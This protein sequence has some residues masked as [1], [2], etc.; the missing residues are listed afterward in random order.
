VRAW[1]RLA[2][3][4]TPLAAAVA[5][6]G[7]ALATR[8]HGE[9]SWH[10]RAR[11]A[12]ADARVL[13]RLDAARRRL[14]AHHSAPFGAMQ[15]GRGGRNGGTGGW[16]NAAGHGGGAGANAHAA[17]Q[18]ILSLFS[19]IGGH[20]GQPRDRAGPRR[21]R[22]A[23]AGA[24]RPGE[25]SCPC[26]FTT[27]RPHRTACHACGRW[28]DASVGPAKG[29]GGGGKGG[30][31]GAARRVEGRSFL[32][33]LSEPRPARQPPHV[34]AATAKGEGKNVG[35]GFVGKGPGKGGERLGDGTHPSS[36]TAIIDEDGF[37]LVQSRSGRGTGKGMQ[38]GLAPARGGGTEGEKG[39]ARP[40]WSDVETDDEMDE[41]AGADDADV[42][43]DD[44]EEE[45]GAAEGEEVDPRR[46]RANYE[47]LARAVR[48]L[49]SKG[50]F[51]SGGTALRAL[52]EA[53]DRAERAWR[54]A[55][56]P[57]PLATRLARAEAKK[58]RAAAALAK[59]RLAVDELDRQYDE[60]RAELC[61]QVQTAESW[62]QWRRQQEEE[63][64]AEAAGG[65]PSRQRSTDDSGG[66]AD[67]KERIRDHFLP[68]VQSIMEHVEGNPEI[69]E[70]LSVLAAGLVDAEA[71][72]DVHHY[73]NAAQTFDISQGDV[74]EGTNGKGGTAKASM[75]A[76]GEP[77]GKG[78]AAQSA[79]TGKPAEW[80]PEGP[81]R[82]TRS[83]AAGKAGGGAATVGQREAAAC[84]RTQSQDRN[85][86]GEV[87]DHH[88]DDHAGAA[89]TERGSDIVN[90]D[91]GDDGGDGPA[92]H[93]RMETEEESRQ[94]A[95]EAADRRRAE[96]LRA[97]QDAATE[98][99]V[100]SY[101]AGAGGFGSE[102]ALSVAAQRYVQEVQLA[103][104]RAARMGIP[105][106]SR[107]GRD[108]IELS[109]MELR[110]W[111]DEHLVEEEEY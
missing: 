12:R 63:L 19:G 108:L 18:F 20:D 38:Q 86:Q 16:A 62:Y 78:D 26:G 11:R 95:R 34:L 81:G 111:I 104:R 13:V 9:P 70:R 90:G 55:K 106:K 24:P 64:L 84:P 74:E 4:R 87:G 49:G 2:G 72:L 83:A 39:A 5:R 58:E 54:D 48:N 97:Q 60:R 1:Q 43:H 68:Q 29:G 82:W 42:D 89:S 46:L 10:R 57:A 8:Q 35:G 102:T 71:R 53:R 65:A 100:R 21:P 7:R 103:Q 3:A 85:E 75:G 96:E 77:R 99:Q 92:K 93:R 101:E 31:K 98:A 56:P 88:R 36:A 40:R 76:G 37:Q 15:R 28:R 23:G 30:G 14:A 107:D 41:E 51:A 32:A 79:G 91:S 69:L 33:A 22:G 17:R 73:A 61:R 109:P 52:T 67:V 105:A 59:V 94:A 80:R 66:G 110:K 27:N 47:E 44:A 50:G 45:E 25:W 6:G